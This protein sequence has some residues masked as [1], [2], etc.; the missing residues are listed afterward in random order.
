MKINRKLTAIKRKNPSLPLQKIKDFIN[1]DDII[2]DY[3]CGYGIDVI[4]M[5]NITKEVYGYDKF[6]EQFSNENVLKEDYNIITCFYVL[7]VIEEPDERLEVLEHIKEM[8]HKKGKLFIAV[9]SSYELKKANKTY[10]KYN[11]G[12]ITKRNT[13]QKYFTEEEIVNLLKKVFPNHYI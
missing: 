7:N 6:V 1:E 10:T 13:F 3:G 2:L 9:R 8:L 4:A 12:I 11:D 5:K